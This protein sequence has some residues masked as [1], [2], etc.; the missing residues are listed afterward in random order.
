[1]KTCRMCVGA[2]AL[3]LIGAGVA[4]APWGGAASAVALAPARE[5]APFAIDKVHT[6]V[7]FKVQRVNGAPFYGRF[8]DVSGSFLLNHDDPS[9]SVIDITIDTGSVDTN[10][11]GRDRHLKSADFFAAEEQPKATFKATGFAKVG[12][13]EYDVTGDLTIRGTTKPITARVKQTGMGAARRGVMCG[14]DVT[15][16]IK[17]AEFGVNYGPGA[18]SDEVHI[19]AGLEGNRAQ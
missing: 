18:L 5:D 15:F 11:Q 19:M 17:R 6:S 8:N 2:L 7:V 9:K 10:S 3:G 16:A 14:L 13:M 1:M 4:V 12:E